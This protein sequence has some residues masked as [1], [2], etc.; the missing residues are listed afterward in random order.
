MAAVR[1][2]Q[3]DVIGVMVLLVLTAVGTWFLLHGGT[4]IGLDSATFFY[5]MYSFLGER[6][7]SF[8]I[9]GW[10]PAQ[11]SG[12]PFAA[13]PESGWMYMPAMLLFAILPLADAA[14]AFVFFHF[15]LVGLTT[16]AL[17]RV[18]GLNM[19][20]ALTAAVVAEFA[21]FFFVMSVV[22]PIFV[23]VA[24]WLPLTM[25]GMELAIRSRSRLTRIAW[26]GVAGFALSQILGAWLG[27]GAYFAL[28]ALGSYVVYRTLFSPPVATL[29]LRD[30]L[31][32][33]CLHGGAVLVVSFSLAAAGVLPRL[34]YRQ[35]SNLAQGYQL[36]EDTTG[37]WA[38]LSVYG[39][40][41][42]RA[43]TLF[44][45]GVVTVAL[46]LMVPRLA[47]K[48]PAI[49]YFVFL[50]LGT[51]ALTTVNT[52]PESLTAIFGLLPQMV[53]D[54]HR[55]NP[56]RVMMVFYLGPAIMAG[57]VISALRRWP[58]VNALLII[59]LFADLIVVGRVI[60]AEHGF[61]SDLDAYY[62]PHGAAAFLEEQGA[63]QPSRYFGYDPRLSSLMGNGLQMLYIDF[64]R[65]PAVGSLLVTNQATVHGLHDIQGYNPLHPAPYTELIAAMNGY[66]QDYH[67]TNVFASGLGS[68]LLDLMGT[69][70]A[71]VPSAVPPGRPDLLH[72]SQDW[73][74]VYQDEMVRV[75]E[76][77]E[78]LPRAW[79]V[80]EARQVADGDALGLLVS[81]AVDPRW[82]ALLE[83]PVPALG[84][85]ADSTAD[86][87][88]VT[89][90]EPDR[91]LIETHSQAA[92]LLML[93]ESYDPNW[94]AYVDGE[95]VE[96]YVAD[97][98]LRAVPV[99]T[100]AHTVELRYESLALRGGMAI[101][102]GAYAVLGAVWAAAGWAGVRRRQAHAGNH[103]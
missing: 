92:S 62:E 35:L 60:V 53:E 89:T 67:G 95:R 15:V 42:A 83:D 48:R 90:Y 26:W 10:N 58:L 33:L 44:Y 63:A 65:D 21:G 75:L 46:A 91:I 37:G 38:P 77:P 101:S 103:R 86:T 59:V 70:N 54:F 5:P 13:D 85:P 24:A 50:S 27:Q 6:L 36:T 34:E 22:I 18:L 3:P 71:V 64:W 17:A 94:R 81:G 72:L 45:V 9:P 99:P 102:V 32:A 11:F 25:L 98:A 56:Q 39:P 43:N 12:A 41:L 2:A 79:L 96:L 49:P 55:H 19:P 69:R 66:P 97:H 7:A 80:H 23:Q 61:K 93:S 100:G 88:V 1:R 20:G 47:W 30:R 29:R 28:L 87:A 40:L 82:V 68:P 8:D 74:T 4:T 14:K 16:Y 57:A 76:N 84:V 31:M 51:L 78:A 73:P 52:L